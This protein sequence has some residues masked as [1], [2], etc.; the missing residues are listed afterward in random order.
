MSLVSGLDSVG[1]CCISLS[2]LWNHVWCSL[3]YTILD[4]GA[5]CEPT[6]I[7]DVLPLEQTLPRTSQRLPL[8]TS[9]C[10][11]YLTHSHTDTQTHTPHQCHRRS[12][13]LASLPSLLSLFWSISWPT[14][15]WEKN[16]DHGLYHP[17]EHG[18][19][20][21]RFSGDTSIKIECA[22]PYWKLQIR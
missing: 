6:L 19:E 1:F 16:S 15:S 3:M 13:D 10:R 21:G 22:R 8:A 11:K 17:E 12:S 20:T 4:P 7:T 14:Q 9:D 2:L 18:W 5:S